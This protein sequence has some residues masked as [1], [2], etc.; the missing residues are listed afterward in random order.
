[1]KPECNTCNFKSLFN[2]L[3]VGVQKR[4]SSGKRN[5]ESKSRSV[6]PG[7]DIFESKPYIES[8][9]KSQETNSKCLDKLVCFKWCITVGSTAPIWSVSSQS[10]ASEITDPVCVVTLSEIQKIP[11]TL[12]L[13]EDITLLLKSSILCLLVILKPY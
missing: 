4:K 10:T 9:Q 6:S 12:Y 2:L 13:Y 1:M 8:L 7:T 11:L 3:I 5:H